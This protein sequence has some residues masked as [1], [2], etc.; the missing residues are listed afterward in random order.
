MDTVSVKV[1]NILIEDPE[2]LRLKKKKFSEMTSAESE[3][4]K[5]KDKDCGEFSKVV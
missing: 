3:Y 5:Q 4:F 1:D 2:Y